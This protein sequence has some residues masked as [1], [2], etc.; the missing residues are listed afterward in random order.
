MDNNENIDFRRITGI[1]CSNQNNGDYEDTQNE[2]VFF[3][4]D[5]NKKKENHDSRGNNRKIFEKNL[6][7]MQINFQNLH[8]KFEEIVNSKKFNFK[9]FLINN[10]NIQLAPRTKTNP[11]SNEERAMLVEEKKMDSEEKLKEEKKN[12]P[13]NSSISNDGDSLFDVFVDDP[14]K[15]NSND[16]KLLGKKIAINNN[17]KNVKEDEEIQ[18]L[19]EIVELCKQNDKTCKPSNIKIMYN[20]NISAEILYDDRAIVDIFF[21]G[22]KISK[23]KNCSTNDI[24]FKEKEIIKY[25]KK[26]KKSISQNI[27]RKQKFKVNY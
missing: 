17:N 14:P 8:L 26:I 7:E 22:K 10:L 5:S 2:N 6:K 21:E 1:K 12:S 19:K 15:T 27:N 16:S 4:D 9:N 13:K 23:I 18:L 3:Y 11:I 20:E 24:I 25:L